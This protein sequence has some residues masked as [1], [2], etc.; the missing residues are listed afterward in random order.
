MNLDMDAHEITQ[1]VLTLAVALLL[2]V[3]ITLAI[4]ITVTV[5]IILYRRHRKIKDT[6][7]KSSKKLKALYA[8]NKT[9]NYIDIK[10]VCSF[11]HACRSKQQLDHF[12]FDTFFMGVIESN[13]QAWNNLAKAITKNRVEYDYYRRGV[14]EITSSITEEECKALGLSLKF[15]QKYESALFKKGLLKPPTTELT[16]LCNAHYVSPQGRNSYRKTEEYNYEAIKKFIV[17]ASQKKERQEQ[18]RI[19]R[20]KMTDS[21][22]YDI[23]KRDNFKCQICGSAAIDGVKLHVDHIIPVSKGGKTVHHNLKTLCDRCNMGKSD[24]MP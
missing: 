18:I 19:E 24:K 17:K 2:F 3:A 4:I 7:L 8:L 10:P 12:S 20:L 21:L 14:Q 22:R 13:E 5:I 16:I 15:F 23:L 1:L 11:S 6:V 9:V